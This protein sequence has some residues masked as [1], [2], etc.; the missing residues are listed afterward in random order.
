M[1]AARNTL[2]YS[3]AKGQGRRLWRRRQGWKRGAIKCEIA[4]RGDSRVSNGVCS[5]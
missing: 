5:S 4:R 1:S 3:C 2:K